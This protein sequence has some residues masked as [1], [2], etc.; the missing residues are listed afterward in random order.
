MVSRRPVLGEEHGKLTR[1][2]QLNVG[3]GLD[4]AQ[5][6]ASSVFRIIIITRFHITATGP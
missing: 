4:R 2:R 6:H 3:A 5:A 1:E